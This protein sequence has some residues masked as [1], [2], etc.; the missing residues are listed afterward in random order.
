[1]IEPTNNPNNQIERLKLLAIASFATGNPAA[2]QKRLAELET[3]LPAPNKESDKED[4]SQFDADAL[5]AAIAEA[6]CYAAISA[7][8]LAEAAKQLEQTS[9]IP[10]AREARLWLA[11]G[12]KDKAADAAQDAV[13]RYPNQVAPLATLVD[14]LYQSGKHAEAQKQFAELR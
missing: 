1:Y 4:K 7:G 14:V 5:K 3:K 10:K 12:K 2:G 11:I 13:K 9:N 6:K 8:H